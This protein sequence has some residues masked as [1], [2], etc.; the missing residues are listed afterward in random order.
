MAAFLSN[1]DPEIPNKT[2]NQC[3]SYD[4]RMKYLHFDAQQPSEH[5]DLLAASLKNL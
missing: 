5:L 1:L 3:K 2:P 4:E